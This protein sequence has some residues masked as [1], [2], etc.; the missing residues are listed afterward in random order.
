MPSTVYVFT[1]NSIKARDWWGE[2]VVTEPY[3]RFG[4]W[5]FAVE[6]RY[7]GAIA[8]AMLAEGL[9]VGDDFTVSC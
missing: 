9:L 2:N 4:T 7:V 1:L 3:Q 8:E 6:H 5:G